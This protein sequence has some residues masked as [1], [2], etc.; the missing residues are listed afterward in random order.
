MFRPVHPTPQQAGQ[1][2]GLLYAPQ[3]NHPWIGSASRRS[4]RS[5]HHARQTAHDQR[6]GMGRPSV[7]AKPPNLQQTVL[8]ESWNISHRRSSGVGDITPDRSYKLRGAKLRAHHTKPRVRGRIKSTPTYLPSSV[9]PLLSIALLSP[10][11]VAVL[12]PNVRLS[13]V[14]PLNLVVS[15]EFSSNPSKLSSIGAVVL[16]APDL[17]SMKVISTNGPPAGSGVNSS[18]TSL[19]IVTS[20]EF[21]L[22]SIGSSTLQP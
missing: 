16:S 19:L 5:D 7:S 14:P 2:P 9:P 4:I 12:P 3:P 18:Q 6:S 1:R 8:F 21:D 10:E 20:F 13:F 17:Q 22:N 15:V 11:N